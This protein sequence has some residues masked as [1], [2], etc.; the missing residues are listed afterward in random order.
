[1]Q[2]DLVAGASVCTLEVGRELAAQLSPGGEEP[3]REV[4]E[5]RP[6]RTGQGHREVVSHDGLI[7]SYSEE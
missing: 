4:H 1:V 5:P 7:P 6:D 3:L 2:V